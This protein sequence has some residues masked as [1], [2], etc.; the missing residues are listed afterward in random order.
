MDVFPTHRARNGEVSNPSP[1][2]EDESLQNIMD[3][4]GWSPLTGGINLFPTPSLGAFPAGLIDSSAMLS[5]LMMYLT[6][7]PCDL[8]EGACPL[9]GILPDPAP[10][11]ELGRGAMMMEGLIGAFTAPEPSSPSSSSALP[12]TPERVGM[13]KYLI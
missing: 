7:G 8:P 12:P 4:S 1:M 13:G 10:T 11:T 2:D 6:E 9:P 3:M 5:E